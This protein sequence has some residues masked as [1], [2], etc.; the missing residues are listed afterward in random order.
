M[1][2]W[3]F[4]PYRITAV[5]LAA[6]AAMLVLMAQVSVGASLWLIRLVMF[7]IG[8]GT[9]VFIPAQAAMTA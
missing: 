7:G 4:G 9:S 3:R 2:Y 8:L 5:G 6:V 1:L